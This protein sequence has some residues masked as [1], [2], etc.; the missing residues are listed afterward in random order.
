M[1][2][3]L[4]DMAAVVGPNLLDEIVEAALRTPYCTIGSLYRVLDEASGRGRPGVAGLRSVVE[5]RGRDHVPTES[6]LDV[7]GRQVVASIDGIEWQ[8]E[9][10]DE[11]GYIR[12]VDGFHRSSGLVIE[13]DGAAFHDLD[14]QRTLDAAQDERFRGMGLTVLRFRWDDVTRAP[15]EVRERILGHILAAERDPRGDLVG[16]ER[17]RGD[18]GDGTDRGCGHDR[19]GAGR[20]VA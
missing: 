1:S 8:V 16:I 7:L 10:S 4:L 20:D 15:D 2:R 5:R 11:R 18:E 17:G 9:L 13:W 3:T 19:R 14:R 12:R 6:E